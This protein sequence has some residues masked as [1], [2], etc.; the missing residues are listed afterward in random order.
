MKNNIFSVQTNL[1][2]DTTEVYST[3]EWI[4]TDKKIKSN[5]LNKI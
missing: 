2:Q 4:Y 1:I 5:H 3:S